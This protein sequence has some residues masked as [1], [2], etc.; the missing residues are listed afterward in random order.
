MTEER[1]KIKRDINDVGYICQIVDEALNH[2]HVEKSDLLLLVPTPEF[3]TMSEDLIN[4]DRMPV[5]FDDNPPSLSRLEFY[6][7]E[8]LPLSVF[9]KKAIVVIKTDQWKNRDAQDKLPM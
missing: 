8:C 1:V 6:G 7:V 9:I 2:Y 3:T 5:D 4:N